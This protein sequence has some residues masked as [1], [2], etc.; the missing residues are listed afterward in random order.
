MN[1]SHFFVSNGGVE[2]PGVDVTCGKSRE[3][4]ERFFASGPKSQITQ[5][6]AGILHSGAQMPSLGPTGSTFGRYVT[7]RT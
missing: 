4:G 7:R 5:F 2:S 1:Y 3:N 6:P